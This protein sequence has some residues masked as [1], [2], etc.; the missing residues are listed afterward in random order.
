MDISP[1][2]HEGRRNGLSIH[3]TY[4]AAIPYFKAIKTFL[5]PQRHCFGIT[6]WDDENGKYIPSHVNSKH[7]PFP[8]TH[9][10]FMTRQ[11][12]QWGWYFAM[13]HLFAERSDP[14]PGFSFMVNGH[15]NSDVLVCIDIDH[16]KSSNPSDAVE[17]ASKVVSGEFAHQQVFM[18]PS[19]NRRGSYIW[20]IVRRRVTPRTFNKL[21]GKFS[22]Y[23]KD[24][25][26]GSSTH[27]DAVKCSV[28]FKVW[29]PSFD[30]SRVREAGI[31]GSKLHKTSPEFI[32]DVTLERKI[33]CRGVLGTMPCAGALARN[34]QD[35][36]DAF[37]N[38]VA[39]D[40]KGQ[41]VNRIDEGFIAAKLAPVMQTVS[42]PAPS[43]Q[44]K[45][46]GAQTQNGIVATPSKRTNRAWRM[47]HST[48]V[49]DSRWG[50][51]LWANQL[52][53][54]KA[55]PEEACQIY[56]QH[57]A[58]TGASHEER[59]RFFTRI[60]PLVAPP[61]AAGDTNWFSTEDIKSLEQKLMASVSS[62]VMKGV[63]DRLRHARRG[64]LALEDVARMGVWQKKCI[65][66]H[67]G[68]CSHSMIR[69]FAASQRMVEPKQRLFHS[70]QIDEAFDLLEAIGFSHRIGDHDYHKNQCRKYKLGCAP[71]LL[72]IQ[73]EAE[74]EAEEIMVKLLARRT[75]HG[76]KQMAGSFVWESDA[77]FLLYPSL[78]P[79]RLCQKRE[80]LSCKKIPCR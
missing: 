25:Y 57:G 23:L 39:R 43:L 78:K 13:A 69:G 42:P 56:E 24:K 4:K 68:D 38:F 37:L 77:L 64:T 79:E 27:V 80:E 10:R 12:M 59:T 54:R 65:L 20:L 5:D 2:I 50:A 46:L 49:L 55:T 15:L 66:D 61:T 31:Y 73:S 21:L 11:K 71:N 48:N 35:H 8:C 75:S 41:C 63:V 70:R 7:N 34:E 62:N 32:Y 36:I 26:V 44:D 45:R 47:L 3:A 30:W 53:R 74:K 1:L 19:R 14:Q 51:Y 28:E 29:N 52:Y 18:E 22:S 72:S 6:R 33:H 16:D 9:P 76:K 17:L 67:D 40:D 58:A 60:E